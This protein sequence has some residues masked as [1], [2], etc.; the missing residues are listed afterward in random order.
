[1]SLRQ[2]ALAH[3]KLELLDDAE[4][5]LLRGAQ[6]A[7]TLGSSVTESLL[8]SDAALISLRQGDIKMCESRLQE[9]DSVIGR[10]PATLQSLTTSSSSLVLM[11]KGDFHLKQERWV[12]ALSAYDEAM[13]LLEGSI[14]SDRV[15]ALFKSDL[16][17]LASSARG[18]EGMRAGIP[19]DW[20]SPH[21]ELLSAKLQVRRAR[22]LLPLGEEASRQAA[23]V[24]FQK[25][26]SPRAV[27][28]ASTGDRAAA[29][30]G[31]YETMIQ[32]EKDEMEK[33]I[34]KSWSLL[35][36]PGEVTDS[37]TPRPRTRSATATEVTSTFSR[38][39]ELLSRAEAMAQED[40]SFPRLS[41]RIR[42]AL[43]K[44]IGRRDVARTTR[45]LALMSGQASELK[46]AEW[47]TKRKTLDLL[48]AFD[49]IRISDGDD[50]LSRDTE[51]SLAQLPE[52]WSV[53]GITP[54]EEKEHLFLW[55]LESGSSTPIAVRQRLPSR[56]GPCFDDLMTEFKAIVNAMMDSNVSSIDAAEA[57]TPSQ[58]K[59]WWK[60]RFNLD[61]RLKCLLET[62]E[63]EWLGNFRGLLMG[64]PVVV[65]CDDERVHT[66]VDSGTV[67]CLR[68]GSLSCDEAANLASL[69]GDKRNE[70]GA[71]VDFLSSN[72]QSES[73]GPVILLLDK[74]I[75]CLPW[76]SLPFLEGQAMS[77]IPSLSLL[78]CN[79]VWVDPSSTCYVLNPGGDL[80]STENL[81]NDT[82]SSQ[83]G[84]KGFVGRMDERDIR[85]RALLRSY[86]SG[87][88]T[89]LYCGHNGA[90]ALLPPREL[91]KME[92]LPKAALLMGC[93]SGRLEVR[94]EYDAAGTAVDYLVAGCPVVVG[95]LWDVTD[96][97]IDRLTS[98]VLREWL[99]VEDEDT[100]EEGSAEGAATTIAH[101]VTS[102][103][104]VC[105]LRYLVGAATVVYGNPDARARP[106]MGTHLGTDRGC[107]Q[108]LSSP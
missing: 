13:S 35:T 33:E 43:A 61:N 3:E 83:E 12:Q 18:D 25:V 68:R 60:Q 91:P 102:G 75:Q 1:M 21:M 92:S 64:S 100:I 38:A 62:I 98:H 47:K 22:A 15:M 49:R 105:K 82:F 74:S 34:Q 36:A 45:C 24:A 41:N 4:Y 53:V 59:A 108:A 5:Y 77:R 37:R 11:K 56:G 44:L 52:G 79:P 90:E 70:Q 6:L 9:A 63:R 71:L 93:G 42:A 58:K 87:C 7:R 55:R 30:F 72:P 84:W 101:A 88:D 14:D 78:Y 39:I 106:L 2:V 66:R 107:D 104:S 86:F 20:T 99:H 89:F 46:K 50:Y 40:S 29:L 76:E 97:D 19:R 27:P 80:K 26:A 96:K 48:D 16:D 94:G 17:E 81:F 65:S 23:E 31:C 95:N 69:L 57:L 32:K 51:I 67:E 85:N 73:R 8:L 28:R 103:R 54:D 10:V